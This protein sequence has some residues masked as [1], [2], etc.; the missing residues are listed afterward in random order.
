MRRR[1]FLYILLLAIG[2]QAQEKYSEVLS[3]TR[4][5]SP[6]EAIYELMDYQQWKPEL[7]GVYFELGNLSYDL[8]PTRVPW[9][10]G[11]RTPRASP[12]P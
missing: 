10:H 3:R 8:L 5:L 7:P 4:T 9:P 1:F 11:P 6:Y 12:Q 2:A